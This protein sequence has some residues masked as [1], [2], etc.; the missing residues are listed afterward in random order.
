MILK[1][2]KR[3]GVSR[4]RWSGTAPAGQAIENEGS[5]SGADFNI[6]MDREAAL[7]AG[8]EVAGRSINWG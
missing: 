7:S 4:L 8:R 2:K 6:G 5:V 3:I 1:T